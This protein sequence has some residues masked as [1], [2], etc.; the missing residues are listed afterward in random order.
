MELTRSRATLWLTVTFVCG[1]PRCYLD[2]AE[3]MTDITNDV[4]D[5]EVHLAIRQ[6]VIKKQC[7]TRESDLSHGAAYSAR[8]VPSPLA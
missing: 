3:E 5:R 2:N 1:I 6:K 4:F 8:L 7:W